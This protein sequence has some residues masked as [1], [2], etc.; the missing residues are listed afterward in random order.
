MQ[1]ER[2]SFSPSFFKTSPD[3][4][5]KGFYRLLS[6]FRQEQDVSGRAGT[7]LP[8]SLTSANGATSLLLSF[9]ESSSEALLLPAS[10]SWGALNVISQ[11]QEAEVQR[12]SLSFSLCPFTGYREQEL[13][14]AAYCSFPFPYKTWP[15]LCTSSPEQRPLYLLSQLSWYIIAIWQSINCTLYQNKEAT[16]PYITLFNCFLTL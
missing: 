15:F 16:Q 12:N 7:K 10:V 13:R 11:H 6:T 14:V 1:W 8:G 3:Q 4:Q 2:I 9:L 5:P